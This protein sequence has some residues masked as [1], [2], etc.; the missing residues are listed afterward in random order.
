MVPKTNAVRYRGRR[1]KIEQLVERLPEDAWALVMPA[2]ENSHGRPP[3]EWACLELRAD[4]GMGM[5]H[6]LLIRR[7]SEAPE[8]LTFYQAYGPERTSLA[9]ELIGVCQ[10]RWKVE[11]CFAEAKGEVGIEHY[12]V[13]RWDAWHRYITLCLLAHAFLVVTRL[14][15]ACEEETGG[16]RGIS[17]PA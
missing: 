12:E 7:S 14:L 9:A 16:K 5:R 13:R 6:W 1:K 2:G 3:G 11:D 15:G 17:I 10:R 8:D 4:P